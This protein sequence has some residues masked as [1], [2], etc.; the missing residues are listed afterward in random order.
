MHELTVRLRR[1]VL[2]AV[3][4]SL[5][6]LAAGVSSIAVFAGEDAAPEQRPPLFDVVTVAPA[7]SVGMHVSY[8]INH[9]GDGEG[10]ELPP[11]VVYSHE[12][13]PQQWS[14]MAITDRSLC[15]RKDERAICSDFAALIAHPPA[16]D[17]EV[18]ATRIFGSGYVS[19]FLVRVDGVHIDGVDA[20]VAFLAGDSQDPPYSELVLY[21]Y[22]RKGTQLIQLYTNV[23]KCNPLKEEGESDVAYYRR[24]CLSAATLEK[25]R[26][27]GRRLVEMFRLGAS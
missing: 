26:A 22:A 18:S 9:D 24:N 2:T 25:A 5:F 13:A 17:K 1:R 10:E 21:L 15:R 19:T 23:G 20:Q 8:E 11:S 16:L 4:A 12:D 6:C 7:V 27:R 14:T 3:A